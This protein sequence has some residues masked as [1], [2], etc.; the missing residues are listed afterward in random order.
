MT[1]SIAR[2]HVVLTRFP[3]M[4]LTGA[5]VRPALIVSAGSIGQ[6]FIL[7]G[8][9]SVIRGGSAP[10]DVLVDPS[11]PEFA[12][13]GLRVASALRLHKLATVERAVVIRLLGRIGPQ[14]QTEVDQ[15]LR[16]VLAL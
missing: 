3:F 4:D 13:T 10:T 5:S 6:D 15:A 7:A 12:N 16:R 1:A 8:I 2:G 9:S 11:H 14:L